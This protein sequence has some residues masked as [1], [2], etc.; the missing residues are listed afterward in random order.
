MFKNRFWRLP[1]FADPQPQNFITPKNTKLFYG[2]PPN[3]GR[4][5][6][7]HTGGLGEVGLEPTYV[8]IPHHLRPKTQGANGNGGWNPS[9]LAP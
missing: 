2:P 6:H 5:H 8:G 4:K 7:L 1:K 9:H 3:S